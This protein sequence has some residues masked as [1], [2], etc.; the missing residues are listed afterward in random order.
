MAPALVL[1]EEPRISRNITTS[2]NFEVETYDL[3]LTM[4]PTGDR[5]QIRVA[6]D[7]TIGHYAE[8]LGKATRRIRAVN[9]M[10]SGSDIRLGQRLFIPVDKTGI[11]GFMAARLEYHLA[12]EEDFYS[13]YVVSDVVTR[14]LQRGETLWDLCNG[15]EPIPL[16]LL[17]KYNRNLDLE[18]LMPGM[19]VSIPLVEERSLSAIAAAVPA[20][21]ADHAERPYRDEPIRPFDR[22]VKLMP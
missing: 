16:W 11:E 10:G 4:S 18:R 22:T 3:E 13:Q 14:A 21:P 8:W 7:E 17:K 9:N 6:I 2:A 5:A 19:M 20:F 1:A 12:I 15:D